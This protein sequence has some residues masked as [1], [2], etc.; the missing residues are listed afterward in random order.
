MTMED[1]IVRAYKIIN[2]ILEE[3]E[4]LYIPEYFNNIETID[5]D[6]NNLKMQLLLHGLVKIKKDFDIVINY[7]GDD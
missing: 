3:N 4:D 1:N 6:L 7:I 5:K 2:G